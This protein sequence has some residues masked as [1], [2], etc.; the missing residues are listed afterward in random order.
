LVRGTVRIGTVMSH[1]LDM[2]G[3]LKRFHFQHPVVEI[4]LRTAGS[5]QLID[6]VRSGTVDLAV[7]ALGPDDR[8]DGIAITPVVDELIVAVVCR[9]HALASRSTITLRALQDHPLIVLT[10]G[11]EIRRQF[12]HAC[13][14]AGFVP[15]IAFEVSTPSE[16]A[17]LAAQ[18]LGVAIMRQSLSRNRSEL[19]AL[20]IKPALRAQLALAWRDAGPISPA[21]RTLIAM[22][23]Q[24]TK[25]AGSSEPT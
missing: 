17:D 13:R 3:L 6:A 2:T 5:D 11:T 15:H 24:F 20:S 7:V 1:N 10:A 19:H 18:G 14:Q 21:A 23:Q 12:D 16:L 9:T 22:S 4:I 25:P 8:P